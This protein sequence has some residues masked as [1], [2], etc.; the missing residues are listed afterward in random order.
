LVDAG[1]DFELLNFP[2]TGI[3]CLLILFSLIV[4]VFSDFLINN[5]ADFRQSFSGTVK[6]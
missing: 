3:W 2:A 5:L 6:H 1:F 4:V